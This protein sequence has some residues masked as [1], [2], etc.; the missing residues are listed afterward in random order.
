MKKILTSLLILGLSSNYTPPVLAASGSGRDLSTQIGDCPSGI[1]ANWVMGPVLIGLASTAAINIAGAAVDAVTTY[2]NQVRA[3]KSTASLALDKSEESSLLDGSKCLYLFAN[4]SELKSYLKANNNSSMSGIP[5]AFIKEISAKSLTPFL[6]AIRF[7]S[8]N[9]TEAKQKFYKPQVL[10]IIYD[11]FLDTGCPL[12]RN[13]SRRDVNITLKLARP[14]SPD[15]TMQAAKAYPLSIGFQNARTS[16]VSSILANNSNS[17]W[18]GLDTTAP[19]ISNLEFTI[20]ETSRPGA[21]A[22]ALATTA[23]SNKQPIQ[24]AFSA[25]LVPQTPAAQKT[26]ID[27]A[28]EEYKTYT[29]LHQAAY[30]LFSA[31]LET[32]AKRNQYSLARQNALTQM[33]IAK[34]AWAAAGITNNFE[35]LS[36]LPSP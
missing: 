24:T 12:F 4:T 22:E 29:S 20:I 34:A 5:A 3:T 14:I 10:A 6:A 23:S 15:G 1:T 33:Q 2:L 7:S 11:S 35:A 27:K 19:V 8:A 21:L 25:L 32:P 13:C 16:E 17:L 28:M 18:F 30:K 36:A 31:G 26:Q 9:V